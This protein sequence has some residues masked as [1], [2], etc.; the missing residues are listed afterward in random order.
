MRRLRR[1]RSDGIHESVFAVVLKASLEVRSAVVFGSLIVVLVLVPVFTLEGL[2]GAFFKPLALAYV[3]AILASL[4]VALT[5]TP[6]LALMLL[7][8]AAE[9]RE[10]DSPLVTLAQGALPPA[11]QS[12][13]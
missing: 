13:R 9:R 4:A 10:T 11:P 12:A 6:A 8:K 2:S 1:N 3:T 5:L 7:P